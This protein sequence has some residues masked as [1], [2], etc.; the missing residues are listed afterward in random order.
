MAVMV[1]CTARPSCYVS[2]LAAAFT[3]LQHMCMK[4]QNRG[5][6][7]LECALC[8][9]AIFGCPQGQPLLVFVV[10]RLQL[11]E[12]GLFLAFI[13]HKPLNY[14]AVSGLGPPG[15]WSKDIED[16][17]EEA[18]QL[19]PPCGRRKIILSDEGKM[20]GMYKPAAFDSPT[21]YRHGSLTFLLVYCC[22][23]GYYVKWWDQGATN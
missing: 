1:S 7:K 5:P 3:L 18:L 23:D 13:R 4:K 20:F 16:A 14:A 6:K 21:V 10:G 2:T 9:F 12:T 22:C 8:S 17:F 19:Y 11:R 15:V